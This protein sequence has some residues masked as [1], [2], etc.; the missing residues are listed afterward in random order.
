MFKRL[1][2]CVVTLAAITAIPAEAQEQARAQLGP[3]E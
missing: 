3:A 2:A 1:L